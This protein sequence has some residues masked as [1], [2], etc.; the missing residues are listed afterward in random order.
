M[1]G[2][3][4]SLSMAIVSMRVDICGLSLFDVYVV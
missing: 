1:T 4:R 3:R 2:T